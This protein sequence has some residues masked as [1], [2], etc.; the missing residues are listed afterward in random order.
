M[1]LSS[2]NTLNSLFGNP[3]DG[4]IDSI[5]CLLTIPQWLWSSLTKVQPDWKAD[6][7]QSVSALA[8]SAASARYKDDREVHV[9]KPLCSHN[10]DKC[11]C[12][13]LGMTYT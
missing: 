10:R 5:Y 12:S 4:I 1:R 11:R 6:R 3:Q 13:Y 8:P 7:G 9:D 2:R